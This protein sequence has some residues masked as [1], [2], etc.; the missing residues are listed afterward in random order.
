MLFRVPLNPRVAY[1]TTSHD[2]NSKARTDAAIADGTTVNWPSVSPLQPSETMGLEAFNI[3]EKTIEKEFLKL[4]VGRKL[5]IAI[6]S[7]TGYVS[8]CIGSSSVSTSS[9]MGGVSEKY[10]KVF[11]EY[12]ELTREKDNIKSHL[13]EA[14][15]R[16]ERRFGELRH[17]IDKLKNNHT[18]EVDP[19][20]K[21]LSEAQKKLEHE[22]EEAKKYS[23]RVA[24]SFEEGIEGGCHP[25]G[26]EDHGARQT[27]GFKKD[28][29][30]LTKDEGTEPDQDAEA[31][32]NER[33]DPLVQVKTI[34]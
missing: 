21:M 26:S 11:K 7:S 8:F 25:V 5:G 34:T 33:I 1:E 31:M 4:R 2:C 29:L 9:I 27:L 20:T 32:L 22:R 19:L 12:I 23:D 16:H 14:D 3:R 15:G 13:Q 6:A 18:A 17:D 30:D 24:T 10:R 28:C